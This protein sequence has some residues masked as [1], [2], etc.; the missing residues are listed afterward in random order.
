[1]MDGATLSLLTNGKITSMAQ[2]IKIWMLMQASALILDYDPDW[3]GFEGENMDKIRQRRPRMKVDRGCCVG[4]YCKHGCAAAALARLNHFIVRL[5]G[6]EDRIQD[7]YYPL[8]IWAKMLMARSYAGTRCL[9]HPCTN[10]YMNWVPDHHPHYLPMNQLA[11]HTDASSARAVRT[12]P[13]CWD[14]AQEGP[15]VGIGI[16]EWLAIVDRQPARTRWAKL[17]RWFWM[18][19]LIWY[20]WGITQEKHCGPDGNYRKRDRQAF[21]ED[22]KEGA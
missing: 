17:R 19:R 12:D 14:C 5:R 3:Q 21:E 2:L 13:I 16:T 6:E 10:C 22:G 15:A 1:M 8:R 4:N 18:S 9:C 7:K 20:W 11:A